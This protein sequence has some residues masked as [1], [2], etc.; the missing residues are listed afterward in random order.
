VHEVKSKGGH[1]LLVTNHPMKGGGW[2]GT[3]ETSPNGGQAEQQRAT[4]RTRKERRAVIED[5][6]STFRNGLE[7]LLRTVAIAREKCA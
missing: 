1:L 6:I 5:A 4:M 7:N 3:H 2:I